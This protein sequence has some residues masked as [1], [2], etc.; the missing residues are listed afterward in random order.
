M[1]ETAPALRLHSVMLG[2]R[3]LDE[4]VVFYTERLGLTL[5]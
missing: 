3:D 2:V 1:T 5:C 4:S